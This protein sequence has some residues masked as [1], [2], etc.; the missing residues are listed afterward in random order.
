M[1]RADVAAASDIIET[2]S[3][4]TMIASASAKKPKYGFSPVPSQT[5]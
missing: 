2:D 1:T 5:N 3:Q 4:V